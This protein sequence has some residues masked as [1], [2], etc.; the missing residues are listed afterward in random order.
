MLLTVNVEFPEFA[1][2][3]VE[4]AVVLTCTFPNAR[5]PLSP[6]CGLSAPSRSRKR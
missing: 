1:M 3:I 2:V 4:L 6:I 5:F